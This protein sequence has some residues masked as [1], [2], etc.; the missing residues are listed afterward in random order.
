MCFSAGASFAGGVVITSI[1]IATVRKAG[2]SPEFV[3]AIIPLF[4]GLQQFAEGFLWL[5]LPAPDPHLN[6]LRNICTYIFMITA[7]VIW[8]LMIPYSVLLMERAGSRRKILTWLLIC[9]A[10]VSAYYTI[11]QLFLHVN[12]RIEGYHVLYKTDFPKSLSNPVFFVYLIATIAPLFVSTHKKMRIMAI[13]MIISCLLSA[14]FYKE[15]L[16]SVWCFFAALIS[17]VIFWILKDSKKPLTIDES[18]LL[19]Q[20]QI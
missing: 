15:Y 11:C 4:F 17:M 1:G 16:T 14:I 20:V 5:I 10:T 13:L 3:F 19:Q 6:Y 2:R 8:P 12:A 18:K 9:G 7:Q